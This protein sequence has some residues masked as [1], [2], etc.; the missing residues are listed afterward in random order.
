[1]NYTPLIIIG[2]ALTLSGCSTL[3]TS[4]N[5]YIG[6]QTF[7]FNKQEIVDAQCD[8]IND[9]GSWFVNTPGHV[10]IKKS[11]NNLSIV[12]FKQ[13]FNKLSLTIPSSTKP[14]IYGNILLGG[15]IGVI[16]DSSSGSS[17]QYP[18]KL[19]ITLDRD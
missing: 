14:G 5:Q 19:E 2:F 8:I 17:F 13:G 12:C 9:E 16:V 3:T 18:T 4:S 15:F 7:D 6:I 11:F 1:M 10:L